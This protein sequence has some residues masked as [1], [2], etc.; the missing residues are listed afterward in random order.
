MDLK[1]KVVPSVDFYWLDDW[2]EEVNERVALSPKLHLCLQH[3]M[4]AFT[5]KYAS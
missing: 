5:L 3:Y 2:T 4:G 1:K